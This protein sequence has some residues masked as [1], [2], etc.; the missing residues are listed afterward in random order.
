LFS[1]TAVKVFLKV[2]SIVDAEPPVC[3]PLKFR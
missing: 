2:I 3:L 1:G